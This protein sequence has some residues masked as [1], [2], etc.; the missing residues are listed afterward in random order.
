MSRL[1]TLVEMLRRQSRMVGVAQGVTASW[2]VHSLVGDSEP[3]VIQ[4]SPPTHRLTDR[5]GPEVVEQMV[6]D[7]V[8]G[9][10][11]S[12]LA[13]RFPLS[14]SAAL[15]VMHER[16]VA[17][18]QKRVTTEIIEL[19]ARRYGEGLSLEAFGRE[20]GFSASTLCAVFRAHGIN[21]R[22]AWYLG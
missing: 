5:L 4:A 11:C 7:Y 8:T 10:T 17:R 6:A 3:P 19:A 18:E 14:K 2:E 9:A 16:G 13:R 22:S 12:E 15:R 1:I 20:V 21:T